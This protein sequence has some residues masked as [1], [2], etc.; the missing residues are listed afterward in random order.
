MPAPLSGLPRSIAVPI[1]SSLAPR[2]EWR[3]AGVSGVMVTPGPLARRPVVGG[4]PAAYGMPHVPPGAD[5]QRRLVVCSLCNYGR[6]DV[7]CD[8]TALPRSILDRSSAVGSRRERD[9]PGCLTHSLPVTFRIARCGSRRSSPDLCAW[10]GSTLPRQTP[11][12][13]SHTPFCIWPGSEIVPPRRR[14]AARPNP[15]TRHCSATAGLEISVGG[16]PATG[17]VGVAATDIPHS[18]FSVCRSAQPRRVRLRSFG[19]HAE[20]GG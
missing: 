13:Y 4:D 18:V 10:A 19:P 11:P 7:R 15:L 5:P 3:P 9:E 1:V 14:R 17:L 8:A 20:T 6:H 2:R 12:P 16:Y